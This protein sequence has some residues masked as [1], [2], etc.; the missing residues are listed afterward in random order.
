VVVVV[1]VV[2]VAAVVVVAGRGFGGRTCTVS[3]GPCPPFGQFATRTRH[4][5]T[6]GNR[7]VPRQIPGAT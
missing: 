5:P 1:P 6:V 4:R 2:V 7:Y 3:W